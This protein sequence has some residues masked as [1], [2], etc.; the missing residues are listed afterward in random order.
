M[1]DATMDLFTARC[2]RPP[3]W[4]TDAVYRSNE[5]GYTTTDAFVIDDWR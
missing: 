5:A 3:G 1:N 2:A 4:L